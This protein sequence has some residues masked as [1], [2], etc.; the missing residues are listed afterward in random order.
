M[1]DNNLKQNTN[2]DEI[3][4]QCFKEEI[5]DYN[6]KQDIKE[7]DDVKTPVN[8][9]INSNPSTPNKNVSQRSFVNL[10]GNSKKLDSRINLKPSISYKITSHKSNIKIKQNIKE[11]KDCI[12]K[13]NCLEKQSS[14]KSTKSLSN[15]KIVKIDKNKDDIGQKGI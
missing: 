6:L 13:I 5:Y 4:E 8:E 7:E 9:I 1:Y 14:L 15:F 3:T 10:I 11:N 12:N 2:D